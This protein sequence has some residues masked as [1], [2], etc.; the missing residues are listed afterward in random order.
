MIEIK[1]IKKSFGEGEKR[2][3][4]LD[5]FNAKM[6]KGQITSIIGGSGSGKSTVLKHLIGAY[7]P[8]SGEIWIDGEEVSQLKVEAVNSMERIS[9][10]EPDRFDIYVRL[11]DIYKKKKMFHEALTRY[12][13]ALSIKSDDRYVHRSMLEIY[14]AL[15]ALEIEKLKKLEGQSSFA[16][17]P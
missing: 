1:N 8:D 5:D 13:S 17:N 11:G 15:T 16:Q 4:V 9:V 6:E 3:V 7:T 10:L 14:K 12:W 2:L